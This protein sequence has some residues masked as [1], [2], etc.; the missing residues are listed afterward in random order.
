LLSEGARV[1]I[2]SSSAENIR[3]AEEKLKA[4]GL[5]NVISC[6]ADL[7][8]QSDIQNLV[9]TALHSFGRIDGIVTNCGGPPAGPPLSITDE[10][11]QSA[12]ESVFMSVVRLCRLVV[13]QMVK[14]G[15]GSIL[16]ITSTSVKQPIGNLTTSNSLR[17]AIVGFLK[18][19]SDE[20]AEKNVRVN[21]IAPGR[22]LT[23]RTQELD[24]ALASRTG[25]T[26]EEVRTHSTMEIPMKRLGDVSE[27][28][29]VCAFLLSAKASYITG[30]TICV[31]GGR[32]ASLF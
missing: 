26:L 8:N 28:S 4:E 19:L 25:K 1:L 6:V 7:K 24:R 9:E 13:P 20:F 27:F 18:Y 32:V 16:A 21:V 30:Q 23:D 31:D 15:G 3:L 17:P 2:A 11:W 12:F 22:I 5:N 10:Q 29:G 14:Q